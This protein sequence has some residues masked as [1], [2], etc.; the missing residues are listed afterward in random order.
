MLKRSSSSSSGAGAHWQ[1]A[2]WALLS[3]M[4][5]ATC[6]WRHLVALLTQSLCVLKHAHCPTQAC[7]VSSML[8]MQQEALAGQ[9]AQ[10]V[11]PAAGQVAAALQPRPRRQ[12]EEERGNGC[13][14]KLWGLGA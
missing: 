3:A 8:L 2:T 12:G 7:H 4:P 10:T 14:G 1:L 13:C 9:E 6:P 11:E 5:C